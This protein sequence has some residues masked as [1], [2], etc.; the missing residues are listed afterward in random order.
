M[1]STEFVRIFLLLF[2]VYPGESAGYARI[3]L[4][5]LNCY[6]MLSNDWMRHYR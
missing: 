4:I 2:F 3:P 5:Y 1:E 6:G